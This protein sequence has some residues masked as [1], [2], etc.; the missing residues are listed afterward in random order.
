MP[1]EAH[2][3][4]AAMLSASQV[5]PDSPLAD[6]RAGFDLMESVLVPASGVRRE[7]VDA[8]GVP[9]TWFIPENP[10]RRTVL[11]LHGGGYCIGSVKSHSAFA[12]HLAAR[13]SVAV[14]VPEYRLAPEHPAPAAIDD[15]VAVYRWLL[16][17]GTLPNELVLTGDSAG[18]GLVLS[19]L[20]SL[21]D[22]EH[23]L[24]AGGV[25]ISPFL[26]LTGAGE[27]ARSRA[28]ED[29]VLSPEILDHWGSLYRGEIPA[30]DPL[31]SP[32]FADLSD[33]PPLLVQVGTR[34]LLLDD[35]RRLAERA[36][37]FGGDVRLKIYEGIIH[38]WPV[39]GAG[40]VPE[41]DEA[42]DEIAEFVAAVGDRLG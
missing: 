13:L 38:A 12:S 39:M 18:G 10:G 25:L 5:H 17:Q 8:A 30:G 40:L 34:E 23:P 20:V 2:E 35:A 32:L 15:A 31:V 22:D 16:E 19:A 26:D 41:A 21:R 36:P 27:S 28:G 14:L 9:A 1:S 29:V 11:H 3:N 42:I 7:D 4:L 33:L 6:L 24:P 37:S